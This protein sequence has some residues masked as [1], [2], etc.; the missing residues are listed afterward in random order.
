MYAV[1]ARTGQ[2]IWRTSPVP[3][4]WMGQPL[5]QGDLVYVNAGTVGFNFSNL[6]T[7]AKTGHAVRGAGVAYNGIY[8][9]DR[10]T[11]ALRWHVDTRGDVMPTPALS[12]GRLIFSTGAGDVFAVDAR[13]GQPLWHTTLGGMA[14]MSSPAV[15][16]GK[17][18]LGM[19]APALLYCLDAA[20]G[21]VLWKAT[22]PQ[23]VNTSLGDVS[24]AV[25]QGVVV[26]DAITAPQTSG[27][28]TT[29]GATVMAFDAQS[30]QVLW[31][32][33]MP[34]GPKPPS[35]KGGVPMI[36]GD[37]VYVGSPVDNLVQALDLHTGHLRWSW[38][39]PDRSA[40]GSA[41][42]P[43]TYHDGA[44]YIATVAS[45]Y[46]VDAQTGHLLGK[47]E[48]GGRFGIISPTIVGGTMYLGNSW[49]WLIALPL[50]QVNPR[51]HG[52]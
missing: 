19:S 15:V 52:Q 39:V 10:Y 7:F 13:S 41:R 21:R 29:V 48:I 4:T 32:H 14:N 31:Q 50:S 34:R 40:A 16:D 18:Y 36:H 27:Q 51:A 47:K 26:T 43:A 3:T 8:A 44:L 42:G 45:V 38:Q 6:Q 25:A 17:V 9:L 24:P 46:A 1:N 35:Y 30:G 20:G 28:T 49:D 33:Q 23:A 12:Q 5:V 37:T 22:V 11:G 2:L